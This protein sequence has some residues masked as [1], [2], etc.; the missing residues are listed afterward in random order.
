MRNDSFWTP[1]RFHSPPLLF[2]VIPFLSNILYPPLPITVPFSP[3]RSNTPILLCH[4]LYISL[5]LPFSSNF[6]HK[7]HQPL[8]QLSISS[9][10]P[11]KRLPIIISFPSSHISLVPT[12][13]PIPP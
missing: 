10:T 6:Q 7:S 9:H 3:L 11:L 8:H 2:S 12:C 5:Q 4:P 1:L 13:R